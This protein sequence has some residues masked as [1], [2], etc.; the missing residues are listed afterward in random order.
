MKLV[1]GDLCG[2]VTPTTPSGNKLFFLLVDDL[3]RYMW[4]ILLS[5]KDQASMVFTAFQ[6]RA[7]AEAARKL[8]TLRTDRGDEFTARNFI[9]HCTQEGVQRHYT[10]PYT[11]QQNG[12]VERHNQTVMGMAR[13]M[14]KAMSVPGWFWGEAVT[15]TVF[16][17]NWSPTQSVDGKTPFE[18]WHGVKPPVHFLRTFGCVAHVKTGGKHLTKLE[19]QSTPMVFVDYEAGT[20]SWRFYNPVTQRVH[21]SHDAVFEESRP[22]DW[23]DDKGAGPGDDVE[24]F[25]IEFVTVGGA[26]H[27]AEVAPATPPTS[28]A[29]ATPAS[30]PTS[31]AMP[32]YGSEPCTSAAPTTPAAPSGVQFTT[33]PMGELDLDE[34][35][36]DDAPL[37]FRTM[38]NVLGLGSPPGLADR[39]L[40]Q[41]LLVAIG[42]EPTSVK[43]AKASKEWRT[44]MLEEMASIEENKTWS[45]VDLPR[46]HHAIG[47][48]W[49]FKLK[50][51]EHGEIVKHKARLVAKGYVQR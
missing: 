29:P 25:Y 11:P 49:V 6:A 31:A 17:L 51:D 32:T 18:V 35:H 20:K 19:D 38:D 40:T 42:D 2:P 15:T 1:H 41:E 22:W 28:P 5:T 44:A 8:R 37:R 36:D 43:E 46:G 24:P 45:L 10:A 7:E 12:V 3:S 23:G 14:M 50:R 33:P 21:V 13:S 27:E 26:R 9:E 39:E 4:L 16:I 47:L 34:D 48:K 30:S